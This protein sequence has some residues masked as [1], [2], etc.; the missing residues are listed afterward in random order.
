MKLNSL[1]AHCATTLSLALLTACSPSAEDV[2]TPTKSEAVEG[3]RLLDTKPAEALPVK[4]AKATLNPG[5]AAVI[6][7]KVGGA[8]EPFL[9][10]YAG[11]IIG[12]TDLVYCDEMG[13]DDHCATPWDA[14]CEDPDKVKASRAS[15]TFVDA[16][17][18][19]IPSGMQGFA[20]IQGLS[21]VFIEGTVSQT[22]T[23]ENLII[24][25]TGLYVQK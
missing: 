18:N 17:G 22:S 8:R 4:L 5:D 6:F 16:E 14:C 13:D 21:E 12:D 24:E 11:F 15:V 7:G 23:P 1:L 9:E 10:G 2:S 25:A 3:I 19:V 20:G